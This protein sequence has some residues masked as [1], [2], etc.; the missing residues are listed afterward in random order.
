[1]EPS[2]D[3]TDIPHDSAGHRVAG[4]VFVLQILHQFFTVAGMGFS[5]KCARISPYCATLVGPSFPLFPRFLTFV[6]S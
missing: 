3:A 2:P 4:K 6:L 5:F 1:M